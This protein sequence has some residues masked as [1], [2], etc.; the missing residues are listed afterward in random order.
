[1]DKK[2]K[3]KNF[4]DNQ[5]NL[6]P[7]RKLQEG[8]AP[9]TR[10]CS[11]S[12]NR[13]TSKINTR[14]KSTDGKSVITNKTNFVSKSH[15]VGNEDSEVK[16]QTNMNQYYHVLS[17]KVTSVQGVE[18][19][20]DLRSYKTSKGPIR[21]STASQPP[22]FYDEDL[23]KIKEKKN[24]SGGLLNNKY[25]DLSYANF[26]FVNS[27]KENTL[28]I[29]HLIRK[30]MGETGNFS[31]VFFETSMRQSK[32]AHNKK[33]EKWSHVVYSPR[34]NLPVTGYIPPITNQAIKD[35]QAH[36]KDFVKKYDVV[37][38]SINQNEEYGKGNKIGR[39]F[40]PSLNELCDILG[41]NKDYNNDFK[42]KNYSDFSHLASKQTNPQMKWALGLR[43]LAQP[44]K[45]KKKEKNEKHKNKDIPERKTNH[46]T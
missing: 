44:E 42:Y 4:K 46:K 6:S 26:E 39:K 33:T 45:K 5:L 40:V 25:N 34:K 19:V 18:Y 14:I 24:K 20:L 23:K 21:P 35:V 29:D 8:D 36:E 12:K 3:L 41:E 7:I 27:D 28:V 32:R 1:M 13:S 31:Q 22:K 43:E 16:K 15:F 9:I 30:R 37:Y 11:M 17:D 10:P 2:E 38:K